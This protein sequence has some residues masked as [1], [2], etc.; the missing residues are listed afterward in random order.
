MSSP[1]LTPERLARLHDAAK[2][3]AHELRREAIDSA[4]DRMVAALARLLR[5]AGGSPRK[6]GVPRGTPFLSGTQERRNAA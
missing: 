5:R 6:K 1:L 4:F 2:A 3:R